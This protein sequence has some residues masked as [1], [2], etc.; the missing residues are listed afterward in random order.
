M[1]ICIYVYREITILKAKYTEQLG[2]PHQQL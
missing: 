1:F 2:Y